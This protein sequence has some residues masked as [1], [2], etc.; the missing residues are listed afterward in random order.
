MS[1]TG[2]IDV[3][4]LEEVLRLLARSYKSGCLRVD[5]S[6]LHGRIFLSG[7]SLTFATVGTD[8][9]MRRQ[10]LASKVTSDEAVRAAEVGGRSLTDAPTETSSVGDFFREEVV[11]SIYRIRKPGKGQFVFNVDVAPKYRSESTFDVELCIAE[12]DRRAAEWADIESVITG[13]EQPLRVVSEAPHNEPVTLAPNT[14]KLVAN[15]EGVSSV[16]AMSDRLGNSRFRV[17]KD[18]AALV[19]GGLVETVSTEQPTRYEM[20]RGTGASAELVHQADTVEESIDH[21]PSAD[22]APEAEAE[23]AADYN[24]SWWSEAVEAADEP[25]AVEP[26]AEASVT[27]EEPEEPKEED[28]SGESFLDKVF[29]QLNENPEGQGVPSPVATQGFLKRRRMS[30]VG[31]DE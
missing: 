28:A 15:F 6:D 27:E 19:R 24:R 22:V 9:D 13:I 23:T 21:E 2:H 14:W 26:E 3:F 29:S 18:L 16:R 1:L 10:L 17:A 11:E 5:A 4:P 12:A 8:E 31:L 30:S 20:P 7:G 25:A